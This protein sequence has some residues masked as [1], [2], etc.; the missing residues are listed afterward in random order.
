[1]SEQHDKLYL[2]LQGGKLL[3]VS[4]NGIATVENGE[5]EDK[6]WI[7]HPN[8]DKEALN[9]RLD[10]VAAGGLQ[11]FEEL[12]VDTQACED[13][14]MRWF[15]AMEEGL[16]P[17]LRD[18]ASAR[19][20]VAHRGGQGDGKT[21]GAQWFYALHGRGI[22]EGDA[23]IAALSNAGDAG[24]LV[25]DNK[26]QASLSEPK[27]RDYLMFLS[28]GGRRTRS[29]SDGFE[30]RAT[31]TFR[32]V[33]V[34]TS[35]EGV[36]ASELQRR[37]INVEY[38]ASA[39]DK[40]LYEPETILAAIK[41][42]RHLMLSAAVAVMQEYIRLKQA[43][44]MPKI[45]VPDAFQDF[46]DNYRVLCGLMFAYEHTAGK[47]PGWADSIIGEWKSVFA[48][49]QK[50]EDEFQ[51]HV[52]EVLQS[53]MTGAGGD[54]FSFVRASLRGQEGYVAITTAAA[55][56]FKLGQRFPR[57]TCTASA[58][59]RRVKKLNGNMVY[60]VDAQCVEVT[61]EV[62]DKLKRDQ[63]H[64]RLGLFF[65]PENTGDLVV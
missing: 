64:R 27:F 56:A 52:F 31:N 2:P 50:E 26:E 12:V 51:F 43:G 11:R 63:G 49:A 36:G 53:E 45:D 62:R 15:V 39:L 6:L 58:I 46:P 35:I 21:T 1:M 42:D 60:H 25:W 55:L 19:I 57:S 44:E 37:V 48:S 33:A 8:G 7:E 38:Q 20:I 34:L 32:P 17:Y 14:S 13:P 65:V 61:G 4:R 18:M 10:A 54:R 3:R 22:V 30:V 40:K 9:F 29:S 5:N 23:S 28:T 16:F 41:R 59:G 24:F 47:A